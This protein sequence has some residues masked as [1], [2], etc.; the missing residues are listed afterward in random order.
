MSTVCAVCTPL[1]QGGIAVIRISGERAVDAAS[2]LFCPFFSFPKVEE[3]KGYSCAYGRVI[4][5]ETG[6]KIDDAVL[7]I[8]RAPHSYTGEDT[9][10]ISCHGGVYIA[11]R[12]LRLCLENGCEQADRGEFTKRAFLNGKLSLTQA[13]AVMDMIS[14][15]GEHALRSARLTKEGRLYAEAEAVKQQLV[16]T[17]GE[18]AAWVDYPEEDLPA[19][20]SEALAAS[21]GS[22][23]KRLEKLLEGYDTGMLLRRGIDTVIAGKP[24]VGKSTL[25]NTLLGYERSIVTELAGTT[26]DVIE[27]SVSLGGFE[28][29]LSDTAG[30]RE[31]SDRVESMGVDIARKRLSDCS[32]VIA[33]FDTS[34]QADSEDKELVEYISGLGAKKI[35]VLNKNDLGDCFDRTLLERLDCKI[36]ELSA[37]KGE[38]KEE[39]SKAVAEL[40]GGAYLDG[41]ETIFANERQKRCI[42]K[43]SEKLGEAETALDSGE[44]L[45]AVTVLI[46]CAC[47]ELMALTGEKVTEAVVDEV[48]GKFCVGK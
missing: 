14:A 1:A 25:M 8:F 38:G 27:E 46:D 5:P 40:F 45:D 24:N 42:E 29:R 2:R 21:V 22:A 4:D 41:D 10:E 34:E 13:E 18:L 3:M 6:E 43:A 12:I 15:K 33:V 7:T 31:T 11:K 30:I 17:L 48:F 20:E 32:L 23:K 35:V 28:L 36:I 44:T 47:E 37:A 16:E 26:R 9:A 19:V 39:L